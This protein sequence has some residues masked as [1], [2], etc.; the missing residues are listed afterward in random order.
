MIFHSTKT[1]SLK[2]SL[3]EAVFNSLP[4]DNGL[5]VPEYIPKVSAQ[6]LNNIEEK[7]F[8]E[9]AAE[10]AWT[11]L[12]DEITRAEIEEIIQ[13]SFDF[14]APVKQLG[15]ND[16]VLELF[17]G[18]SM[19]FKD[20]GARFMAALM[21][22]FLQKSQK[23][24]KILVATSG[25]TGGAVALGFYK[26]PG[27]T[28]TILYP[29]GKV[30]EIQERQL[31]TL[32]HNV[33]AIEVDGNFD[34]CQRLVKEAFLD[35]DLQ[36]RFH[37]ASANSINIA[38]LIP[39][40]FYYF[41]AYAQVK[42]LQ[43]PVVFS[44]PSGNFGNLSAGLLAYRMGLPVEQFVASTNLNNTVPSYLE[45]GDYDPIP[46]IETISNAMDVGNPSNFVRLK[47]F[48]QDDW[49]LITDKISGFYFD[50]QQT[51]E[52]MRKVYDAYEYVM[53]PHTAVAY[54]GLQEYRRKNQSDFTGV[55]LSTAHPAKFLELVED[56]LRFRIEIP[57]RL[58]KLLSVEKTSL[59]MKPSFQDFKELLISIL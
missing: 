49:N 3:E 46:S 37:L 20:F 42:H 30:S 56:T 35:E 34:D 29:K 32:D 51:R 59:K 41:S 21:S 5:Y 14:E 31:T 19:A 27:I 38:R 44:V 53:C 28:V 58:E 26:V 57:E 2:A 43:K 16:F 25:D 15:S 9:I 33:S 39:Q 12:G 18:P 6:F 52:A 55:F 10:V 54:Q 1:P 45:S 22:Y 47:T 7:T 17:H 8:N 11:L 4:S 48:M 23:E 24:I 40:S 36:A 13:R 50:D